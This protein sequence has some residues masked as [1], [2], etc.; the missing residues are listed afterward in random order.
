MLFFIKMQLKRNKRRRILVKGCSIFNDP[1]WTRW[2]STH[3]F[4]LTPWE[5]HKVRN[6]GRGKL[7]R[8]LVVGGLKHLFQEHPEKGHLT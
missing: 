1:L 8:H 2:P 7:S 3:D 5:R 4:Y 6:V